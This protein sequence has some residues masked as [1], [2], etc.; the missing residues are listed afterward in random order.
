M[1]IENPF[2][3]PPQEQA[4]ENP[5]RK[6]EI[7]DVSLDVVQ[8]FSKRVETITGGK[9]EK[10]T[11][12]RA[13]EIKAMLEETAKIFDDAN[14]RYVLD[15]ALNISLYEGDFFRDHRDV[16]VSVFSEDIS[17]LA[18]ILEQKG[19]ALFRFPKDVNEVIKEKGVVRHEL[20]DPEKIDPRKISRERLLF[21]RVNGKL[22]IDTENYAWFDVHA[23]DTNENGDIVQLNGTILPQLKYAEAPSYT[24]ENGKELKLSHPAILAYHKLKSGREHPD[25][26]DLIV[27]KKHLSE[28][29]F[30]EIAE[31]LQQ[32]EE[33]GWD[34]DKSK[35]ARAKDWLEKLKK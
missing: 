9:A 5:H 29:D 18:K 34:E 4:Q 27:L 1:S 26:D 13:R 12:E 16:D 30:A 7:Q 22:E 32:D 19:Y 23:L 33:K 25:F 24:M 2:S 15:G 35:V 31:W 8:E 11:E 21:L 17:K 3:S 10:P 6:H 14:I 20:L 28:L